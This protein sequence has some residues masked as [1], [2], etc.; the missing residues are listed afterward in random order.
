VSRRII[1]IRSLLYT[2]IDP[3]R[4]NGSVVENP[5]ENV[6]MLMA[7]SVRRDAGGSSTAVARSAYGQCSRSLLFGLHV[8]PNFVNALDTGRGCRSNLP[9]EQNARRVGRRAS[10]ETRGMCPKSVAAYR[11]DISGTFSVRCPRAGSRADSAA[12]ISE[13]LP[14]VDTLTLPRLRHIG[15]MTSGERRGTEVPSICCYLTAD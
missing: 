12:T 8:R 2:G 15:V 5:I 7:G 3:V 10:V 14:V 13:P 11:R 6:R 9:R 4:E 1:E